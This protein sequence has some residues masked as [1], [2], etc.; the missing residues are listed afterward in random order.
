MARFMYCVGLLAV[1]LGVR[2]EALEKPNVLLICVDDLKPVLGCYGD[3]KA[4]TPAL[5][6]LA[7]RG[8]RFERA[9][10]NQA[11]CSPSRNS[12]M[13]SLRPQ[14][15]GIYD[16]ATHFRKSAPDAITLGQY[17]KG[18]GYFTE[19][20]GKT[21]HTG[22]GN[23]DDVHSWSVP[24]WRPKGSAYAEPKNAADPQGGSDAKGAAW[25][26]ADVSD[27]QYA[28]GQI[29]EEAIRRLQSAKERGKPFFLTVGFLKPHLPFVAPK[30]YWDLYQREAF[31]VAQLQTPPVGAPS[32]AGQPGGELRNYRGIPAKG[33]LPEE[34]Q[35]TLIH[36][37]YA[38]MS[39]MDAQA[40]R[41]LNEL[42]RLGLAE[43]TIVVLW[44]DHGWHLGDHGM[45][46]KHTNYEQAARI[47]LIVSA[48]GMQRGAASRSLV[49]TVDIY[50][51]LAEL[52]GLPVPLN[53]EG[54][55]FAGVLKNVELSHRDHVTH[56]YPRSAPDR[57]NVLG[58]AIRT[59]RYRLVEWKPPGAAGGTAELE[60][61]DYL[62]DP[63]ESRNLAQ[64]QPEVVKTLREILDS[65][66]QAK[67]Q[68]R[69]EKSAAGK[70]GAGG[71][72]A[73]RDRN[74]MFDRR[75]MNGDGKLSR[76]EFLANQTEADKA[77][78]RF[79]KMDRDED[80]SLSREE[81]VGTGSK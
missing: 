78:A 31:S 28:D 12:L 27:Q 8:V 2:V 20:L 74:T 22:H 56:V 73:S 41:V 5:D 64:E 19:G 54:R 10:C 79:T 57:G 35:R 65:Y 1:V 24:S 72:G 29:A 58:R 67:P 63:Q 43:N 15:L 37:Y 26:S 51:T 81:F 49:E 4:Q 66:P 33:V 7:A 23:I 61:Y 44:G 71:S 6:G 11:V 62:D 48:P 38:A 9:Y 42:E 59:E 69:A 34:Q 46:C 25:E 18:H 53:V 75:D 14:T 39:Y 77:P 76:E 3:G 36:G 52:A 60:L 13:T 68:L 16:L 47:P 55:S 32:Y 17:F 40:G 45:W 50:P 21:F 30:K 80:G 70:A